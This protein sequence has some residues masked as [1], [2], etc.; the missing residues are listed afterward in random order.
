M[1]SSDRFAPETVAR[2][3]AAPRD[4]CAGFGPTLAAERFGENEDRRVSAETVRRVQLR[5]EL[6]RSDLVLWPKGEVAMPTNLGA[7]SGGATIRDPKSG[8]PETRKHSALNLSLDVERPDRLIGDQ[9]VSSRS[10]TARTA[11]EY[12]YTPELEDSR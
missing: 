12:G 8:S 2:S 5:L 10:R 4:R 1:A 3:E 7:A 11:S 6:E 9:L